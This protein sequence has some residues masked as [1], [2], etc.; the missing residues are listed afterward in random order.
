[1]RKHVQIVVLGV[2]YLWQALSL[3]LHTHHTA[4]NATKWGSVTIFAIDL[5]AAS[6]YDTELV[7][8]CKTMSVRVLRLTWEDNI[9]MDLKELGWKHVGWICP[10]SIKFR[11]PSNVGK[12][13]TRW[14]NFGFSRRTLLYKV[15]WDIN[16]F[17]EWVNTM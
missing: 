9:K 15:N 3:L 8:W 13:L 4:N 7:D 12:F 11:A 2:A 6:L 17:C 1:M 10:T 5:F 16:D 14:G